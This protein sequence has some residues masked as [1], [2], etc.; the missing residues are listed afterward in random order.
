M[1]P[2]L[3]FFD[4]FYH[5]YR[6]VPQCGLNVAHNVACEYHQMP[7]VNHI[8]VPHFCHLV[9]HLCKNGRSGQKTTN[10]VSF[11]ASRQAEANGIG[12]KAVRPILTKLCAEIFS[13][14]LNLSHY[15]SRLTQVRQKKV[16]YSCLARREESKNMAIVLIG[17]G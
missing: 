14:F 5:N 2:N 15:N 8:R 16:A 6:G 12:I 4:H 7:Q 9:A 17:R 11:D 10:L 3:S 13:N 1:I